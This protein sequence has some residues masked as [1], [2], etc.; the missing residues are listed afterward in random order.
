MKMA[1]RPGA[2]QRYNNFNFAV[3]GKLIESVTG[4]DY[5]SFMQKRVFKPAGMVSTG[6][7][8]ASD[9]I[10]TGHLERNGKLVPIKTHFNAG[11]YGVP[12]GGL[13]TTLID[14]IKLSQ[15][16]YKGQL[17]QKK[18]MDAMWT[19][20]SSK[21]SNTPGWHSRVAGR[22]LVIH[23]GG[24][25]TGIGCVSD[26]K[27][28][29]SRNLYVIIMM[30]KARNKISPADL[31]DDILFECFHIPKEAEGENDGEGNEQ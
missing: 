31:S 26:Y 18:T 27:I 5:L 8:P 9:D 19:P 17:L 3:M 1:F 12:S 28:V 15:A 6:V 7:K 20:Y 25:G 13:Q 16:L 4:M 29:P 14:F 2:R 30:N 11:D 24:G 22:E 21:L 23:K 10:S